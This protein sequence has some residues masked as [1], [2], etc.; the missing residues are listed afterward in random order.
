M[1]ILY[2]KVGVMD[3]VVGLEKFERRMFPSSLFLKLLDQTPFFRKYP[4]L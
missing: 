1:L 2:P 3:V 4:F